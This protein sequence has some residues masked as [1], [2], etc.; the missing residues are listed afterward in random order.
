[1]FELNK[2]A[3]P[4]RPRE[5]SAGKLGKQCAALRQNAPKERKCAGKAVGMLPKNKNALGKSWEYF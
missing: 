3:F 2:S 5:F 1:M 4:D